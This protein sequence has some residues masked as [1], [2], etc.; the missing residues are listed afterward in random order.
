MLGACNSRL[1]G[2]VLDASGG[3]IAKAH[4]RTA[5]IAGTESD[6]KGE[7]SAC[8][9]QSDATRSASRRTATARSSSS[10]TSIGELRYDF[11]LV[12]EAV[13]VGQVVTEDK[14][15]VAN[16]R[17]IAFPD[18]SEGPHHIANGWAM[19]EEDGRFRI[20]GLSPGHYRLV[21]AA[22]GLASSA[23]VDAMAKAGTAA[24][25][26]IIVVT[27][28][29]RVSGHVVIGDQPAAGAR[30]VASIGSEINRLNAG[31]SESG[32]LAA[33]RQ[34]RAAKRP[35]RSRQLHGAAVRGGRAE[36]ARDQDDEGRRRED[37]SLDARV[38]PRRHYAQRPARR[39]RR[40][41]KARDS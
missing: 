11:V 39:R 8:V 25:D 1:F 21:A 6:D 20:P 7:Y 41:S 22:E 12:P 33:R 3:A 27:A 24:G 4:I 34:L 2:S 29:A 23:P 10:F 32:V 37:R 15:P 14:R 5:G 28:R 30:V 38:D 26:T 17:V 40:R 31:R 35:A 16:A 18:P 9:S 36:A 19:T 13:L